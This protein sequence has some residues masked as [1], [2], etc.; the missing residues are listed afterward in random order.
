MQE[1]ESIAANRTCELGNYSHESSED[2]APASASWGPAEERASH[3]AATLWNRYSAVSGTTRTGFKWVE[4]GCRASLRLAKAASPSKWGR[5]TWRDLRRRGGGM[6]AGTGVQSRDDP[7]S[8][9]VAAGM[10]KANSS[11]IWG[12]GSA[13]EAI[14]AMMPVITSGK[15]EG[16]L[17]RG[18]M[19]DGEVGKLPEPATLPAMSASSEWAFVSPPLRG[20]AHPDTW[21]THGCMR[22]ATCAFRASLTMTRPGAN[23]QEGKASG[24]MPRL[25]TGF[26]KWSHPGF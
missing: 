12:Y 14:V 9:S 3:Q 23:L 4:G 8:I 2:K 13:N 1:P 15:S 24:E 21:C 22:L 6:V 25:E 5:C 18:G 19:F 11:H 20:S 17:G 7:Y 16:P 10:P 26:P